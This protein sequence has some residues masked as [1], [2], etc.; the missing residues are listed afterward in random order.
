MKDE[1]TSRQLCEMLSDVVVPLHVGGET[2]S[3]PCGLTE[4]LK[5]FV[6]K[7]CDGIRRQVQG[8]ILARESRIGAKSEEKKTDLDIKAAVEAGLSDSQRMMLILNEDLNREINQS[9]IPNFE[10]P[11]TKRARIADES[12]SASFGHFDGMRYVEGDINVSI[13]EHPDISTAS[14]DTVKRGTKKS[15][16][17][18]GSTNMHIIVLTHE[19]IR[20]SVQPFA[21][22]Q[23]AFVV[24]MDPDLFSIRLLETYVAAVCYPVKV[25]LL[26]WQ[27][28]NRYTLQFFIFFYYYY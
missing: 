16:P 26:S 23:S 17:L 2:L 7:Q 25:S 6:T 28:V 3:L 20:Q 21:D 10:K 14:A 22:M 24:L 15:L 11:P 8:A 4:R 5:M 9:E 18:A 13:L 19:Q 27:K 12:N 1:F